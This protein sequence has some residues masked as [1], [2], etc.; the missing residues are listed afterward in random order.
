MPTSPMT[1]VRNRVKTVVD[2]TFAPEGIVAQHDKLDPSL[3]QGVAVAAVYPNDASEWAGDA[4]T[5]ETE[6]TV[7][8]FNAY[9]PQINEFQQVDP[10]IIEAFAERLAEALRTQS[11]I[12]DP[13]CWYFR[14][15]R[16]T[17]PD[18]PTGNKS[19]FEMQVRAYGQN[20][21]AL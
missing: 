14:V 11:G 5:L 8:V 6:V 16:T 9:D 4:N 3:G 20:P 18:D 12:N 13:Y 2:A 10:T 19:R 1:Q 17:F 7:Q 15:I 21:A